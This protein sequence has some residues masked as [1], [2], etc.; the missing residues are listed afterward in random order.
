METTEQGAAVFD[1]AAARMKAEII[2]IPSVIDKAKAKK[3]E[4]WPVRGNY[5]SRA[6]A[7]CLRQLVYE[8]VA[9]QE[10]TLHDVGLQYIFDEGNRTER[11]ILED[12]T[13]AGI[14]LIE[15][16]RRFED[17]KL[18]I[19]GRIDG[20]VAL[21][22]DG[23]RVRIPVEFKSINPYDFQTIVPGSMES[24]ANHRRPHVRGYLAQLLLYMAMEDPP[25]DFGIL[26]FKNKSTGRYKQIIVPLDMAKVAEVRARFALVN[27]HV[28]RWERCKTE[29]GKEKAMPARIE[30]RTV[31]KGC[32]FKHLCVPDQDFNAVTDIRNDA[33]LESLLWKAINTAAAA[34]EHSAADEEIKELVKGYAEKNM[35]ADKETLFVI[36]GKLEVVVKRFGKGW[37]VTYGRI[38]ETT[39]VQA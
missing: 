11:A 19:S 16:Q 20:K 29:E 25:S 33:H 2:D 37:R 21:M 27:E 24:I 26:L 15:G 17:K 13:E 18:Q 28:K 7:E 32:A 38:G 8:R 1:G 12:L 14:E 35:L 4:R 34:G 23:K 6:G 22:I 3:I 10:K 9:W 39:E 5:P 36:G 31:C 30:D